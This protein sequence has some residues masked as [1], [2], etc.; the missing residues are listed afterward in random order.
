MLK[1]SLITTFCVKGLVPTRQPLTKKIPLPKR[2]PRKRPCL[3]ETADA[4]KVVEE[5]HHEL[6]IHFSHLYLNNFKSELMVEH[7]V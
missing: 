6:V 3:Q 7:R 2:G 5:Y 4:V 1:Q